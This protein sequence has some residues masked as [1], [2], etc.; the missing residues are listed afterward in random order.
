MQTPD[1]HT[2]EM[3][4]LTLFVMLGNEIPGK[5]RGGHPLFWQ[6]CLDNGL[7]E[8][9][10]MELS[11]EAIHYSGFCDCEILTNSSEPMLIARLED[12]AIGASPS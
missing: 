1:H 12:A 2:M 6:A 4:F 3:I 9:K 7:S 5:C 10:M 8:E 11:A